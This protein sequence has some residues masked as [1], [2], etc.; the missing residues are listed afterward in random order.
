MT[1]VP[2]GASSS[3][4]LGSEHHLIKY[5]QLYPDVTF[6]LDKCLY[7]DELICCAHTVQTAASLSMQAKTKFLD[8]GMNLCKW[9]TNSGEL[10]HMWKEKN[11]RHSKWT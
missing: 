8:A 5:Q 4:A 2:F 6:T 3:T 9:S 11:G 10:K 1:R 7:L